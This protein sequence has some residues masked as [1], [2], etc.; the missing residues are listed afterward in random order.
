ML[1]RER[2]PEGVG[3]EG[4]TSTTSFLSSKK[5]GVF[6]WFAM[7]EVNANVELL[8]ETEMWQGFSLYSTIASNGLALYVVISKMKI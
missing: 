1:E 6:W 4:F 3:F 7:E 8:G 2:T 5:K